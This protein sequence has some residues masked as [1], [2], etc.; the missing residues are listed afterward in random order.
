MEEMLSKAW[1]QIL[2]ALP[3]TPDVPILSGNA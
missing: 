1:D 2:L 3:R